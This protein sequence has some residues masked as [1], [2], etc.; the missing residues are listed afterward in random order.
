MD[1]RSVAP[2]VLIAI[3]GAGL[4]GI[5]MAVQLKRKLGI[6]DFVIYDQA[7][8]IGGTW[9]ANKYPGCAVDVPGPAYS[10]SFA[11]NPK[12]TKWFPSQ[13]DILDYIN[14][15]A[16]SYGI[17]HHV[18]LGTCLA[19][20]YWDEAK[21]SWLLKLKNLQTG[22]SF[23]QECSILISATGNLSQPH[24]GRISDM[25][26]FRGRVV[27]TSEWNESV[28]LDGK[29]VAVVGN[30]CSS[31]QLVPAIAGRSHS[32]YQFMRTPQT[33]VPSMNPRVHP[34]LKF[35]FVH[36]PLLLCFCRWI[37]LMTGDLLFQEYRI[38][39]FGDRARRASERRSLEYV[40][41]TAPMEYW[42]LLLPS[43]P[44]GCKRVVRDHGYLACLRQPNVHVI[45]EAI[46]S[47]CETGA[48]TKS[49]K[50]F[51]VDIVILATGFDTSRPHFKLTGRE[52]TT[53]TEHWEGFG[54]KEAYKSVA[55]S[56]FPNFFMIYGPNG[57]FAHTSALVAIEA[58]VNLILNVA[59]PVVQKQRS[60]VEISLER[61]RAYYQ[62]TR[63]GLRDTIWENCQ[64]YYKD[65]SGHNVFLYPWSAAWFYLHMAFE[66]RSSWQY[67]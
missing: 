42:P 52:G 56:G 21:R 4:S 35:I 67:S 23:T 25:E 39:Q 50:Y 13:K 44:K 19:K 46:E 66:R 51:P 10:F 30:G 60:T 49:G 48:F 18:S 9:Q 15:V 28:D 36:A 54:A 41:K 6:N 14:G 58:S 47:L 34:L 38:S 31:A 5:A 1:T 33:Y 3:I 11:P 24:H 65:S 12:Y 64:S 8:S 57:A 22:E 37:I 59:Q 53:L 2:K 63:Q 62:R 45:G 16:K 32:V 43:Y 7:S 61:E 55:V 20:G 17:N 26:I 29:R 40:K 27:H